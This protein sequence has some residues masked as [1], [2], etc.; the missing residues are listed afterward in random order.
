MGTDQG[1]KFVFVVNDRDEVE[2]RNVR[3]GSAVRLVQGHRGSR[4]QT[5]RSSDRRW[6]VTRTSRGEGQPKPAEAMTPPANTATAS[7]GRADAAKS[8]VLKAVEF[9]SPI[10]DLCSAL[11]P[12]FPA[13]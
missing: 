4:P 12:G 6:V 2:R 5:R 3:A 1:Q 13:C 9:L 11:T 8:I 10:R 7:G